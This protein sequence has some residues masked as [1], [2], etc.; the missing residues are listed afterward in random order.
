MMQYM[1][2]AVEALGVAALCVGVAMW[3][4]A[5]GLALA[6]IY[7]IGVANSHR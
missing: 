5:A 6:G 4:P 7:A 1:M 2:I 3:Q